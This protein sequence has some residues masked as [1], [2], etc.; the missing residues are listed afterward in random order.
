MLQAWM[1]RQIPGGGEGLG[2]LVCD[3]KHRIVAHVTVYAR[4]PGVA[5]AQ[6]AY[7][8]GE[9]HERAA[10]QELLATM[11]LGG[12]LIQADALHTTHAFFGGASPT[13][14]TY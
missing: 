5:L 2:Q 3:G 4:A 10:L 1:L 14:P 13:G 8:T 11:V 6:K 12:V 9:S 7:D